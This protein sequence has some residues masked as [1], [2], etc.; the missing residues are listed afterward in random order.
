MAG[1]FY[2]TDQTRA[3]PQGSDGVALTSLAARSDVVDIDLDPLAERVRRRRT[4][5]RIGLPLVGVGIIIGF[6]L[7]IAVYA[8]RANRAGVLG[9]SNTLLQGLQQR[10]ALQVSAYLEPAAHAILLAH[11]MLGRNGATTRAEEAYAFAA[12]VLE[13]TPQVDNVLFADAAGNFMLVRRAAAGSSSQ[14]AAGVTETKRI[15]LQPDGRSVE[16]ITRD[17]AGEVLSRRQDPTDDYD[18]RTRAWYT[19]ARSAA[20]VFWSGVYIF[21]SQRAPGITAAVH[22]PGK[23]P[24][25]VGVDIELGALSRFL[26]GL[27]IGRTGRA[28]IV[29]RAGDMIAGPAPD[30]ILRSRDGQL[31]PAKVDEVGDADLGGSWDHFRVEGAG[32]RIIEV[33][34]RRLISIVTP[35]SN[36]QDW[37]LVI[38]VPEAEFSGFV[39]VNSRRAG[40]L[41]LVVIALATGLAVLL[42]RQGLR[43]DRADRTIA[44]R[45]EVVRQQSVAFARLAAEAAHFAPDGTPPQALSETLA[46]ATGARR[47]G[48]WR[49]V[50]GGQVLRCEDSFEPASGGHVGG[51]ELSRQEAPDLM[52]ALTQGEEV[53][54]PE[55]RRDRRTAAY[56]GLLMAPLGSTS[57]VAVPA[58]RDIGAAAASLCVVMLEDARLDAATRN[59]ARACATLT[60]LHAPAAE[61]ARAVSVA[62]SAAPPAAEP[63][64]TLGLDTA[65]EWPPPGDVAEGAWAPVMVLRLPEAPVAQGAGRDGETSP[66]AHRIACAARDIAGQHA[67]PYLKLLGTTLVAAAGPV[68]RDGAADA[69][70]RLADAAIALREACAGLFQ[71]SDDPA[72]FGIGLD[73][74]PVQSGLLGASPGAFPGLFNIWGDAVRGAGTLAGSA[75]PGAIQASEQ[76]FLLLRQN[77]LFRPRGLFYRPGIGDSRSYVLAGRA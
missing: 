34:G 6:L 58:C 49:L 27:A 35:L 14:A 62:A 23:N 31:A 15:L 63:V 10:I 38:T 76:A 20:D 77:F 3:S 8:D 39:R 29:T 45:S 36:S 19:G 55:A 37:L 59:I 21:F 74:G 46:E 17:K 13:E 11:T 54:A 25:V 64:D 30:R 18:P 53:E 73:A 5:L 60:L 75:P 4:L 51:V 12:S 52:A 9:L 7:G 2:S 56:H 43:A 48:I 70:R 33:G 28:Y 42:V 16:W 26:G 24:D 68:T 57:L 32:S 40:L 65:L 22:G 72:D 47:A 61:A 1:E 71:L 66:R 41:S 69:A 44:E 50:G 67:I